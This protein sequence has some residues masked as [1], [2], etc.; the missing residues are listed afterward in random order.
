MIFNSK[1]AS[2]TF[3]GNDKTAMVFYKNVIFLEAFFSV[4]I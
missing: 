2:V 3:K 1:G 4:R